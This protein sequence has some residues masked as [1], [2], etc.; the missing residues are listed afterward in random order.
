ME[1]FAS[2]TTLEELKSDY[3]K[4][5][6]KFKKDEDLIAD[7]KQQFEE[8]LEQNG[9]TLVAES[10][11]NNVEDVPEEK[12]E[13]SKPKNNEQILEAIKDF[14]MRVEIIGSWIW[15][16]DSYGYRDQLKALGFWYS[17]NKK[18][19]VYNGSEKKHVRSHNKVSD[20]RRKWHTEVVK[21]K[22]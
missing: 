9:W 21:E 22:E 2:N 7:I 20:L 4:Y 10:P 14:N 16:F 19:W 3:E 1:Y 18:A 8:I 11:V 12:K 13:V 15:C 6:E 17:V 5:C